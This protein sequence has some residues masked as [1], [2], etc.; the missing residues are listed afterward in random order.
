[1]TG[2]LIPQEN[3]DYI[4]LD[5]E[6]ARVA[7]GGG[8]VSVASKPVSSAAVLDCFANPVEVIAAPGAGKIAIPVALTIQLLA[9]SAAY[10]TAGAGIYLTTGT[11]GSGLPTW[12]DLGP[13][14]ANTGPFFFG[15]SYPGLGPTFN[16]D[17]D[18]TDTPVFLAADTGNPT[19]GDGD[20]SLTVVYYLVTAA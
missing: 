12:H 2:V 3:S 13:T 18:A 4:D 9:S 19:N 14:L 17:S 11:L 1:M 8:A 6:I 5:A 7:G 15:F 16:W 20:I 10:N